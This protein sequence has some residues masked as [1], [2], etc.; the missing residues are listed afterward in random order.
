MVGSFIILAIVIIFRV[1]AETLLP[2]YSWLAKVTP[3]INY[4]IIGLAAV[5]ALFVIIAIVK[6]ILTSGRK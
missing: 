1:I 2:K 6:A 4:A 3:Y 5:F